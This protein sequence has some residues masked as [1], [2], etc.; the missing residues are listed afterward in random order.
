MF[1]LIILSLKW[2]FN[3]F[4]KLFLSGYFCDF[5]YRIEY[6]IVFFFKKVFFCE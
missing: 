4:L 1:V 3:F 5:V 6:K 2:V